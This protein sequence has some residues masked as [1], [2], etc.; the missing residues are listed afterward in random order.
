MSAL[1]AL[2]AELRA[3]SAGATW[4][5]SC[6]RS[7][8]PPA[9][10]PPVHRPAGHHGFDAS[11][12]LYGGGGLVAT[13]MDMA[14]FTRALL[15]GHVFR[16]PATLTLMKTTMGSSG[17]PRVYAAGL[18][19]VRVG[20][21]EGWGHSGFWNTWSY[22]FPAQDVT[23]AASVTE[24][25]DRTVSRAL[26]SRRR[27]LS[28]ARARILL[29]VAAWLPLQ[30]LAQGT[31]FVVGGG[32][33]PEALVREFVELAGGRGRAHIVVMAMASADGEK[34][35]EDKAK[36]LRGLGATA[37]NLWINRRQA[38][39]DSV[40]RLLDGATGIWLAVDC[41]PVWP[42]SLWGHESAPPSGPATRLV[43]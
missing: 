17:A 11:V 19:G 28:F 21:A 34:S 30:A 32:P 22:H 25:T 29:A 38:D 41:R 24:Q 2:A 37:T 7:P 26:S 31:L 9:A 14:R 33:Q 42:M 8:P 4:L 10:R 3:P 43:P 12:D 35:G 13:P 27:M 1:A 36:Q 16:S 18:S 40:A 39:S 6:S 23:L 20:N 5:E 15:T